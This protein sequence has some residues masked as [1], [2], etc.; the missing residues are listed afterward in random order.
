MRTL[1]TVD[2]V[3]K[4]L[5]AECGKLGSQTAWARRHGLSVP[6]VS[7]VINARREPGESVLQALG[8]ERMVHYREVA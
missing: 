1:L 8:L 5:A 4:R 6:Y 3:R 2:D 7:D